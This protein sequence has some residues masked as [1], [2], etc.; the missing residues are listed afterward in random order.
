MSEARTYELGTTLATCYVE[1][2]KWG[3]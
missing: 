2:W 1:S 3:C